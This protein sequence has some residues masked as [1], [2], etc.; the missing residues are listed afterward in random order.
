MRMVEMQPPPSF[1]APHPATIPRNS[2]LMQ[3]IP[4]A[5]TTRS[6]AERSVALD[7]TRDGDR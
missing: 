3:A 2:L 6:A 7:E 1:F 4:R 5:A